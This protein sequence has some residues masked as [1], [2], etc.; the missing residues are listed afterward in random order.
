MTGKVDDATQELPV[1]APRSQH[2]DLR[3][4]RPGRFEDVRVALSG[5]CHRKAL[6]HPE[7]PIE[8]RLFVA[9]EPRRAA[10]FDLSRVG[11]HHRRDDL[12]L[13]AGQVFGIGG[14]RLFIDQGLDQW[15]S[16][17]EFARQEEAR[18]SRCVGMRRIDQHRF[19]RDPALLL[20]FLPDRLH[21]GPPDKQG[22]DPD[23]R[24]ARLPVVKHGRPHLA[25]IVQHPVI[26]LAV[27]TRRFHADLR[28]NVPFGKPR[29]ENRTIRCCRRRDEHAPQAERNPAKQLQ[30]VIVR[31]P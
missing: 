22:V 30:D 28:S 1:L 21:R 8:R 5:M 16:V 18:R 25:G 6:A 23:H 29:L 13:D 11:G 31:S 17:I 26:R 3:I 9:A 12:A 24:H 27:P 2:A 14:H 15:R 10:G 7:P 20:D 4:D 19:R